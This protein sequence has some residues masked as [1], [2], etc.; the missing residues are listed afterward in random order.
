M[1]VGFGIY[2]ETRCLTRESGMAYDMVPESSMVASIAG[3]LLQATKKLH[4]TVVRMDRIIVFI[5]SSGV[6]LDGLS[7]KE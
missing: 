4:K 6:L 2:S 3:V 5:V 7:K 1:K